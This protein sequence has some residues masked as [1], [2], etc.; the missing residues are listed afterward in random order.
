MSGGF[1]P[2]LRKTSDNVTPEASFLASEQYQVKRSGITL[3]A[4]LVQADENGD[5]I[6]KA[7]T[8]VTP[9]EAT[10]RYGPYGGTTNEVQTATVTGAP[11]GGTF[12]LSFGGQTTDAI[13]FDATAEEVEAALSG[14]PNLDEGDVEVT[15]AANV[16][17]VTFGGEYGTEDVPAL[18]ADGSG[19]T[20]GTTPGVTIAT[21]TAGGAAVAD[22]ADPDPDVSGYLPESVN[23]RDGDV[24]CGLY[25][26]CSVLAARV[27]PA[28]DATIR[29]AVAG[30]I[31][32]Q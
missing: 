29:A 18:T 13:D 2:R 26:R 11:T 9:V 6:L 20:G 31:I 28:P 24:I 5:K 1:T 32:F 10:G 16:Y 27:T 14:L 4:D 30:R 23:L 17:T 19:L 3:D 21:T 7:G 22:L 12:T 25:I 8:F 15:K